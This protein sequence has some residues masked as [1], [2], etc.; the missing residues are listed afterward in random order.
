M[1]L[2]RN[3]VCL[4]QMMLRPL[5]VMW[6]WFEEGVEPM[7]SMTTGRYGIKKRLIRLEGTETLP[8]GM[9]H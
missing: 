3:D 5:D 7:I 9:K 4:R 6:I 2:L 8:Y 1:M